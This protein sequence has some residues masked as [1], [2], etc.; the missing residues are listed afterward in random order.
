M[1][2]LQKRRSAPRSQMALGGPPS[3]PHI[4]QIRAGGKEFYK[5]FSA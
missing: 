1:L 5:A 2:D 4:G 3:V